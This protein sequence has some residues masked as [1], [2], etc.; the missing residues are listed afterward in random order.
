MKQQPVSV[1][2]SYCHEDEKLKNKLLNHLASLK[3]Q[4]I[5][6]DWNDREI[7]PGQDW[8]QEID[9]KIRTADLVLLL[10]SSDFIAS[11]YCFEEELTIALERHESKNCV[12]LP[13]ILRPCHWH[14]TPFAKIQSLPKDGHPITKWNDEDES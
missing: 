4:N 9:G 6:E 11:K 5:I 12:V 7:I 10:V 1:F 2:C 3:R 13:I 14:E 8:Q